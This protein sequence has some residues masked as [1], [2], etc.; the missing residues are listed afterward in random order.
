MDY[1]TL[2]KKHHSTGLVT[3]PIELVLFEC[4]GHVTILSKLVDDCR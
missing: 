4:Y 3:I 1:L 2:Y